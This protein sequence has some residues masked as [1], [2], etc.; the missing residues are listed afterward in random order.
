VGVTDA[1]GR[2][3]AE[4]HR[5]REQQR[6]AAENAVDNPDL[7]REE[8]HRERAAGYRRAIDILS[9]AREA[10]TADASVPD[11][12]VE[13][14]TDELV[15]VEA[16]AD[17]HRRRTYRAAPDT[18]GVDARL[19]IDRWDHDGW[20]PVGEEAVAQLAINGRRVFE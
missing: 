6:A 18:P 7:A 11:T 16:S 19:E 17:G 10:D 1:I 4:L 15:I 2:A 12:G 5:R 9:D 8:Y 14:D 20:R 13:I 3:L